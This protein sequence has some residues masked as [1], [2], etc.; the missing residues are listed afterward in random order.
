MLQV[1]VILFVACWFAVCCVLIA[2]DAVRWL[3]PAMTCFFWFGSLLCCVCVFANGCV[4][5]VDVRCYML[6]VVRCLLIVVVC[7]LLFGVV[8]SVGLCCALGGARCVLCV[9]C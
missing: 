9:V 6:C 7:G 4:L 8:C 5:R 2:V 1:V 3:L